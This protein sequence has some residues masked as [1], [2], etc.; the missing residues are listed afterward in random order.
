MNH[1]TEIIFGFP[2]LWFPV[3]GGPEERDLW[4]RIMSSPYKVR[5]FVRCDPSSAALGLLER[6]LQRGSDK[7]AEIEPE[8]HL[9][10]QTLISSPFAQPFKL[11]PSRRP[12]T[13][14]YRRPHPQP[15]DP[16]SGS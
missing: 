10:Y 4:D 3:D 5:M 11:L 1:I 2:G 9:M 14:P 15:M 7:I 6:V 13:H 16:T 8:T 12:P